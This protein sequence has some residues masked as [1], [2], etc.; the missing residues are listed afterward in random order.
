M[1]TSRTFIVERDTKQVAAKTTI[2]KAKRALE[3]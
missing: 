2:E 3:K 1:K